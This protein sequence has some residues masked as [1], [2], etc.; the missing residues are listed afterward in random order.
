MSVNITFNAIS[1]LL[2]SGPRPVKLRDDETVT[3]N[4]VDLSKQDI[5]TISHQS[6]RVTDELKALKKEGL[7]QVLVVAV[8]L[9]QGGAKSQPIA[10]HIAHMDQARVLGL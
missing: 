3:A 4:V 9:Q 10:Y 8:H 2:E 5:K 1:L 6:P 7:S